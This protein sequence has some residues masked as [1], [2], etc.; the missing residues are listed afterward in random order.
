MP[1]LWVAVPGDAGEEVD[2]EEEGEGAV[3]AEA[4][5][6]ATSESQIESKHGARS[7][8]SSSEMSLFDGDIM[9]DLGMSHDLTNGVPRQYRPALCIAWCGTLGQNDVTPLIPL[10]RNVV[11]IVIIILFS[12][13]DFIFIFTPFYKGIMIFGVRGVCFTISISKH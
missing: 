7:T 9:F 8:E 1:S 4:V 3:V 13:M 6:G 5:S 10:R 2:K 11:V 12:C